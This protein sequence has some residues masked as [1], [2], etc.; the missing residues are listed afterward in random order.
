M[1][2]PFNEE[3]HRGKKVM[4]A[5]SGMATD[6][7]HMGQV[8]SGLSHTLEESAGY[9]HIRFSHDQRTVELDI[10]EDRLTEEFIIY[11]SQAYNLIRGMP[12]EGPNSPILPLMDYKRNMDRAS[13]SAPEEPTIP[14]SG[15]APGGGQ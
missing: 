9:D 12:S 7:I 6:C 11:R 5:V 15:S 3:H 10:Q 4:G 8:V 14:A 2:Q 13:S 1:K